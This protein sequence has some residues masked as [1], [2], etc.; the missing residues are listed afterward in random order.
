MDQWKV[1]LYN[2]FIPKYT[3]SVLYP[4]FSLFLSPSLSYS[5]LPYTFL[6]SFYLR[7][8]TSC[9]TFFVLLST[10]STPQM[11]GFK[12]PLSSSQAKMNLSDTNKTIIL[13]NYYFGN[14]GRLTAVKSN[15]TRAG[16]IEL[17]VRF[18]RKHAG[19]RQSYCVNETFFGYRETP[20]SWPPTGRQHLIVLWVRRAEW[21]F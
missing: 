5:F 2:N 17:Q 4:P 18:A 9:W 14:T 19:L 8:L 16:Y 11:V 6:T 7:N 21:G 10:D 12:T 3:P 1:T 20:A 15:T 13:P